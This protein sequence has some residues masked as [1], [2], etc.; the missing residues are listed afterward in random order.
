M[1]PPEQLDKLRSFVEED[2]GA[3]DITAGLVPDVEANAEIMVKEGCVVAGLEEAAAAFGMFGCVAECFVDE[4]KEAKP[5]KVMGVSG[6]GRDILKVERTALNLLGR[7][8]GIATMGREFQKAAAEAN[9]G[10]KVV[11]TRK[12]AP[13]LNYFDKRAVLIG[14]GHNHRINLSDAFL[15]KDNHLKLVGIEKAVKKALEDGAHLVEVEVEGI[16]GLVAA[17]EAGAHRIMLD[18]FDVGDVKK[19]ATRLEG[20]GLR[21]TTELEASGG[22][23]LE[24]IGEY[25]KHVDVISVGALTHS[26]KNV[27]FSLNLLA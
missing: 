17:A 4:G 10:I 25:A 3:G 5:G 7:M 26:V 6:K 21:E 15:I 2:I 12:T 24:N 23:R 1:I 13:G 27:D 22:I 14:T 8:S 18:N 11:G 9:P 16:D 20:L 19:A